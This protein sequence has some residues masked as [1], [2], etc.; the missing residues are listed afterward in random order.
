MSGPIRKCGDWERGGG[1]RGEE[2]GERA[3][4]GEIGGR[5]RREGED[6]TE[7]EMEEEEVIKC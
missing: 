1:G 5:R 2:G 7:V 4:K 6:K 3:G